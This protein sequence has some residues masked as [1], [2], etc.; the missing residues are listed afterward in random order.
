MSHCRYAVANVDSASALKAAIDNCN[1][2]ED[3]Q[4]SDVDPECLQDAIAAANK[5]DPPVDAVQQLIAVASALY[6]IRQAFADSD[7]VKLTKSLASHCSS[8]AI[9]P[10]LEQ[11]A[12]NEINAFLSDLESRK[13]TV[14]E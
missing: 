1:Y 9:G 11:H 2:G 10:L 13:V 7:F 8:A 5:C 6:D 12:A 14:C 4:S 3:L